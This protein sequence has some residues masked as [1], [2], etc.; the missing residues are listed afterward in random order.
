Y[1]KQRAAALAV[2]SD[3]P[4]DAKGVALTPLNRTIDAAGLHY[5]YVDVELN[6]DARL[7]ALTIR[8]PETVTAAT[9]DQALEL[10]AA[11]WPLQMARELD[12]A[13]L[14][15][16]TNELE[17]G[18]WIFKTAGNADAVLAMDDFI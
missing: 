2:A 5:E 1:V 3:R 17:L 7:A 9:V 6:R 14:G 16:R 4:V 15:L 18:L 10:G 12:D 11:W 8:A 13:I